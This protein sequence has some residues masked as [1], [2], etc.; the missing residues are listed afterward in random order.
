MGSLELTTSERGRDF[1]PM[2]QASG[3]RNLSKEV[4]SGRI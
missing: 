3:E 1:S 4:G 2:I